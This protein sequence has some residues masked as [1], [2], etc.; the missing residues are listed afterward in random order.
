MGTLAVLSADEVQ[1]MAAALSALKNPVLWKLDRAL[2]P[3]LLLLLKRIM[4]LDA[5]QIVGYF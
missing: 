4:E 1:S 2:L 5:V 3:G